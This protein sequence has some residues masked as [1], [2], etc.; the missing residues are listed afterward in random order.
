MIDDL[1]AK[2]E[3]GGALTVEEQK[4]LLNALSADFEKLRTE[5]PEKYLAF[6]KEMNT[7]IS[8]LNR[9]IAAK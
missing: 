3:K 2:I 9:E 6:L 8:D 4:E 5:N 1:K 7:I